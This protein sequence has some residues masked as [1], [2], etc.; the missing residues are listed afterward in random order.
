M[1]TVVLQ[2]KVSGTNFSVLLFVQRTALDNI[3]NIKIPVAALFLLQSLTVCGQ[4]RMGYFAGAG[5]IRYNGDVG[6]H[7]NK[8]I[9]PAE[10]VNPYG[11]I[12]VSYRIMNHVEAVFYYLH[13]TV[14]DADSF[15]T[16]NDQLIRNQSFKSPVDEAALQ[17]EFTLNSISKKRMINPFVSIGAGMFRY[18]PEGNLNGTW[19]DLQP[20]GTEGQFLAEGNYPQPYRLTA[21]TFPVGG[22]VSFRIAPAWRLKVEAAHHI[23]TTDYLDD[24]SASYPDLAQLAAAPYGDIAVQLS[25]RRLE[26]EPPRQGRRRGNVSS[27]DSY[28]TVGLLLVYN[29]GLAHRGY[30]GSMNKKRGNRMGKFLGCPVL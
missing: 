25:N 5:I 15:A 7:V 12:G 28:L 24:V 13:G 8:I 14:E 16:D 18:N 11:K 9:T 22:G 1:P 20:L 29:P 19:Y 6:Q 17:I 27:N 23:S 2:R 3:I 10:V 30:H 4:G 21:F 26:P